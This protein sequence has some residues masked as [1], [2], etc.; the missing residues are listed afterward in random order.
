MAFNGAYLLLKIPA[1]PG[2]PQTWSYK[3]DDAAATVDTANYFANALGYGVR[4][5]DIIER[6]TVTNLGATNEAYST[7]G[8]HVVNAASVS[9]GTID[10]ADAVALSGTDTD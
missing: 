8:L 5:Y 9:A 2:H 6:T 4:L 3:T 1:A 10:V 7:Q